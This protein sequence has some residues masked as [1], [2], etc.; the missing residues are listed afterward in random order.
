MKSEKILTISIIDMFSFIAVGSAISY[1]HT[2]FTLEDL[3]DYQR[4]S[5]SLAAGN[6]ILTANVDSRNDATLGLSADKRN[7]LGT[8]TFISRCNKSIE[9]TSTVKCTWKDQSKAEYRGTVVLNTI[10][11]NYTGIVSGEM[12][13]TDES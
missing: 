11:D 1:S 12:Y 4:K 7:W 2:A 8:Y 3:G 9:S 13:W 5:N 10:G 6:I